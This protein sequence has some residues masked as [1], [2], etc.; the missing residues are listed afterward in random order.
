MHGLKHCSKLKTDYILWIK[1]KDLKELINVGE[2]LIWCGF[3]KKMLG[4]MDLFEN[5]NVYFQKP[6]EEEEKITY[7]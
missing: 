6:L 2:K 5:R 7:G 3:S 1:I 4:K